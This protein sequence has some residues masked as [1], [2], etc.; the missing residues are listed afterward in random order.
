MAETTVGWFPV[1]TLLLGYAVKAVSD[2]LQHRR[3][4]ERERQAREAARQ[5]QLFERRTAFQR[6]TLLDLQEAALQLVRTAGAMNHQDVMAFRKTG[7]WQKQ[8]Y[9]EALS[10]D[11]RLANARTSMLAVRV[12]DDSVRDLMAVVK[13]HAWNAGMCASLE[14][15]DR[16]LNAMAA[17]FEKLNQR[18]GEILRKLDDEPNSPILPASRH[19]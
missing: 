7:K 18:I 15:G 6:Q 13:N 14:E 2:W 17:E 8:L 19:T 12:R 5:D 4:S 9:D 11:S 3:T 1:F 16:A 10:E